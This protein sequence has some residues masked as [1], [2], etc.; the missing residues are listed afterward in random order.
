MVFR[1]SR[2][3]RQG[4]P[5]SPYLFLLAAQSLS[6]LLRSR[7]NTK[8]LS[9]IVVAPTALSVNHLLFADDSLLFAK[10]SAEG[11]ASIKEVID[12]Y[13]QAS[14]QRVNLSKSSIHFSKGC[15]NTVHESMKA[16][17]N[18]PN[19]T[20]NERYLGMPSDVGRSTSGTF[21][22][23]KDRVWTRI[24]GWME[25]ILSTGGKEVLIKSMARQFPHILWRASS[26]L[27]GFV[28]KSIR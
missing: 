18:V 5:I 14:G 3:I 7:G 19:E 22:Y 16:I 6:C 17:L 25:H 15:P 2:V 27:G 4:D 20:L 9:G 8:N 1:P 10:A 26:Y 13:Y 11:A 23:L 21:K 28:R 24:Q 12:I